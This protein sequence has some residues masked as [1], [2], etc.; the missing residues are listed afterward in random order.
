MRELIRQLVKEYILVEKKKRKPGG[1][2]TFSGAL[3]RVNRQ[4]FETDV[5]SAMTA[6]QGEV[7]DA[8]DVLGVSTRRMYDYLNMP[9]LDKIPTASDIE[10]KEKETEEKKDK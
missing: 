7:S 5:R 2:L 9:G 1:G 6:N 8:A 10:K 4:R 3:R